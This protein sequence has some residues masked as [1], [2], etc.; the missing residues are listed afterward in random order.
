MTRDLSFAPTS[1]S[2]VTIFKNGNRYDANSS[3]HH[4]KFSFK[5]KS[6]CSELYILNYYEV[7]FCTNTIKVVYKIYISTTSPSFESRLWIIQFSNFCLTIKY[8]RFILNKNK[9]NMNHIILPSRNMENINHACMVH[10]CS[11]PTSETKTK[12]MTLSSLSI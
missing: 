5:R 11:N 3:R 4:T 6:L 12:T 2:K 7:F 10:G 8:V 9:K 1:I